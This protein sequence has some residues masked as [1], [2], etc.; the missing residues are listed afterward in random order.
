MRIGCMGRHIAP[1][2][3]IAVPRQ[4]V[5]N[6]HNL[7]ELQIVVVNRRIRRRR[8]EI[9]TVDFL[10]AVPRAAVYEYTVVIGV[11]CLRV[12]VYQR[13]E[14]DPG[15][16]DQRLTYAAGDDNIRGHIDIRSSQEVHGSGPIVHE[17]YEPGSHSRGGRHVR[18]RAE[19]PQTRGG[20]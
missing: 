9:Y 10:N 8:P 17:T 14:L 20:A 13:L 16:P 4:R 3:G 7:C 1:C 5:V 19:L 15:I 18:H 6:C 12:Y 11:N 2:S